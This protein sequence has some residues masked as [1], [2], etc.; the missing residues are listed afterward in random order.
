[1]VKINVPQ[2]V[3]S[4]KK[5]TVPIKSSI[6]ENRCTSLVSDISVQEKLALPSKTQ[7]LP[8][9]KQCDSNASRESLSEPNDE[10]SKELSPEKNCALKFKNDKNMANKDKLVSVSK[11]KNNEDTRSNSSRNSMSTVRTTVM[12]SK[13]KLDCDKADM[14]C[15]DLPR[16]PKNVSKR[17]SPVLGCNKLSHVNTNASVDATK[18][19]VPNQKTF[20]KNEKMKSFSDFDLRRKI[21]MNRDEPA[22]SVSI[23]GEKT[24]KDIKTLVEP[25][26]TSKYPIKKND[27]EP[28]LS[29]IKCISQ[30]DEDLRRLPLIKTEEVESKRI[31]KREIEASDFSGLE[32]DKDDIPRKK[33]KCENN[34]NRN[35]DSR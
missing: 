18:K 21:N 20:K 3:P 27:I 2:N 28:V 35:P 14:N 4:L 12:S 11:G 24:K 29:D 16:R 22:K 5:N 9:I 31:P 15:Q 1:M 34:E 10:T 25:L 17:K 23:E 33:I 19:K 6:Q 26:G 32:V 7:V 8:Q 13:S 30:K